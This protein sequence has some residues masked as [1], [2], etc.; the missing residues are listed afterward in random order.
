MKNLY[1]IVEKALKKANGRICRRF[2]CNGWDYGDDGFNSFHKN[3]SRSLWKYVP[4]WYG[5]VQH[6]VPS[7][8]MTV[9]VK[10]VI[11]SLDIA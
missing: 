8:K 7:G 10:T 11:D 6:R 9:D 2:P 1:N 5:N 3:I 4:D